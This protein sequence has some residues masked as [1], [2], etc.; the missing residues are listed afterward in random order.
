MKKIFKNLDKPLLLISAILFI[1]GLIMIFSASNVTAYMKYAASPYRYFMKQTI[2]LIVSLIA[3]F[4]IIKFHSKSYHLI[5]T[6]LVY[7]I[8]AMLIFVLLYGSVKNRS[9]RWIDLGFYSF[10]T[11]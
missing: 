9:I 7:V 4:F 10:Q 2:F 8:G 3:S 6:F 5:T 1:I 11:S